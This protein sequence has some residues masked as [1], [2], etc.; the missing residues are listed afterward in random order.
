MAQQQQW[1]Q[2][3]A[4]GGQMDNSYVGPM[5]S[6]YANAAELAV[7]PLSRSLEQAFA[8]RMQERMASREMQFREQQAER[9]YAEQELL[10]TMQDHAA[11][12]QIEAKLRGDVQRDTMKYGREDA[13]AVALRDVMGASI[14][15]AQGA[16]MGGSQ[17]VQPGTGPM[18]LE[19]MAQLPA[20]QQE[21][22]FPALVI[23][24]K[25]AKALGTQGVEFAARTWGT[26]RERAQSNREERVKAQKAAD[27]A[28]QQQQSVGAW[29][30]GL[31]SDSKLS[32]ADKLRIALRAETGDLKG[33]TEEYEAVALAKDAETAKAR[34]ETR[35]GEFE[36]DVLG[37]RIKMP[38]TFRVA[39]GEKKLTSQMPDDVKAKLWDVARR[40][41][42]NDARDNPIL[43]ADAAGFIK[44]EE[45]G[46]GSFNKAVRARAYEA[47]RGGGWIT[48]DENAAQQAQAQVAA[49]TAQPTAAVPET[50]LPSRLVNL[51]ATSI[52]SPDTAALIRE[53]RTK[54]GLFNTNTAAELREFF[55]RSPAD[56]EV[57][58]RTGQYPG[59]AGTTEQKNTAKRAWIQ[60][61][62]QG[63][64]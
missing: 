33:A 64:R 5:A 11:L 60:S 46:E 51:S 10:Q 23:D 19:S 22:E 35:T 61:V 53:A 37:E 16:P 62:E 42:M 39:K 14:P 28:A 20:A 43:A 1:S 25:T 3:Q 24:D 9:Q 2:F 18:S 36:T 17:S 38:T 44:G 30:R 4:P 27:E 54:L 49:P 6:A 21:E 50:E 13:Q 45:K 7:R 59:K 47:A 29:R 58:L 63:Q 52:G 31:L 40:A 34:D 57:Y 48:D 32:D 12:R 8:A 55:S 15:G 26:E 41:V 56:R